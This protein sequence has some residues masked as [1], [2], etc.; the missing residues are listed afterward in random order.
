MSEENLCRDYRLLF[1][2]LILLLPSP[3]KQEAEANSEQES[4]ENLAD[5]S[6]NGLPAGVGRTFKA[7][8]NRVAKVAVFALLAHDSS[9]TAGAFLQF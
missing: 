4:D 1:T 2:L 8:A 6:A 9:V 3:H 7:P 5:Q